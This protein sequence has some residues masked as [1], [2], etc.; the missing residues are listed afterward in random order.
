[1]GL[2]ENILEHIAAPDNLL[3]SWRAVRGNVPQYRRA[4]SA[5]PDGVSLVDFEQDLH[6]QLNI[7]R[8]MILAGKYEPKPAV[9]FSLKKVTGGQREIMVLTVSDRVAQRATQQVLDPLWEPHFLDCSFGFRPG[10]SVEGAIAC[11][12]TYRSQ[13]LPWVL[14]GDIADC[15]PSLDHDLLMT[16]IR[17][18]VKDRRVLKLIQQWLDAGLLQAGPP[19]EEQGL[20]ARLGNVTNLAERSTAWLVNQAAEGVDPYRA[21]HRQTG[22][23]PSYADPAEDAPYPAYEDP[24]LVS[25]RMR[26]SALQRIASG[27]MFLG[28][29]QVRRLTSNA[30]GKVLL[31]L[32]SPAGRRL[33]KKGVLASGGLTG[34][35]VAGAVA[36]YYFYQKAGPAPAG[37][38]QGSPLSPLF[39][40]IYLH[41]FDLMITK[42]DH[43]LV[44][45]ADDW[46]IL[47]ASRRG[48]ENALG[49][50]ERALERLRLNLN[51]EKTQIRHPHEQ[52][53]WLGGV[54]R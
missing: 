53:R 29:G 2:N 28:A 27:A 51:L 22:N 35:A 37:V 48:S 38:L 47:S 16:Q 54:I 36:A 24:A 44:R 34:L 45:F 12:Q 18:Q 7:L 50:A 31:F 19:T 42:K 20:T 9:S 8:E 13:N 26:R 11:A 15:F 6:A 23:Q 30:S 21:A 4:R 43:A 14:D 5:G 40:N 1:M 32:K 46:V 25:P 33:M 3:A 49:D 39:A 41:L 10:R 17:R 52:V